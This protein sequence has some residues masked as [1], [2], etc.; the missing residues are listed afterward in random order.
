V[1][2]DQTNIAALG[3]GFV[4]LAGYLVAITLVF[5]SGRRRRHDDDSSEL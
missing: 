4:L 1:L 3:G 2:A 5:R